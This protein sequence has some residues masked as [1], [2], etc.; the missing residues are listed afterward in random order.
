MAKQK[1][2][3]KSR[4]RIAPYD[5][6]VGG[7][8]S[9]KG[10]TE[11][12][13][14]EAVPLSD[15][16]SLLKQNKSDGFACVSCSY[17]RPDEPGLFEICEN[18]AK[19]TAWEIT[20]K[21][22]GPDFFAEHTVAELESWSDL[23]LE[24]QGRL[25]E[26]MRWDADSDKY[27]PCS[28][29]EAFEGIA[30]ELRALEPEETVFYTSGR[31]SLEASY[32]YQ[33]LAR[34]YGNNN[35][36]DSSNMC[37]ES[38]S[39]ALPQTIGQAVG[40]V[41]I[42][43]FKHTECVMFFGQNVG[44]NSPRMLHQLEAVRKRDV[45]ILSFNPLFERGLERF[46]NP[47]SP[48]KMLTGAETQ[49]STQYH[50]LKP[51]GDL[52]TLVGMTKTLF[53]MD[54]E[55][56][57]EGRERI[58]DTDFIEKHTHG[59]DEFTAAMDQFLWRDI[60][61]AS[62]LTRADIEA[63]AKVYGQA[64]AVIA[65]YGMGLTQHRS[66]VLAIQM[67]SNLLLLCG[68]IGK[69]GAGIF[70]VRG[71]S[72]VQGQRTV[73][74]TE[75]PKLAPL[76]KFAEQFGFEPPR[77][78]GRD[79]VEACQGVRDGSVKAFVSL[80]GNFIRAIPETEI[81]ERAWRDMKLTVQIITKLNRGAIVHGKTAYLLPCLGRI[82]LDRQKSGIQFVTVEDTTGRYHASYGYSEPASEHLLSEPAIVA[83]MAKALLPENPKVDWDGWVADYAKV[84]DAIATSY[85][86]IFHDFNTRIK[87]NPKGFDRPLPAREREW[88]TPTGKANFISPRSL[89]EDP[90]LPA[91]RLGV[92]TL[93]TLRSNDQFNTTVYGLDDRLRGIDGTRMVLLMNEADMEEWE[94]NEGDEIDLHGAAADNVPR[95]VRGLRVVKYNIPQGACGGYYPECN[96]LLPLW[97]HAKGS[98]VPAAKSIPVRIVKREGESD[99][100]PLIA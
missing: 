5:G 79:T 83:G 58:L 35:L 8:G 25:T 20:D 6:P 41:K 94:L 80:G 40:T 64:D 84:R 29:D 50:Q 42:E 62:G 67:L 69:P 34:L 77:E 55:A 81:M 9:L 92:L 46:T 76:D 56:K 48:I 52:A 93:I 68:N 75:K 65:C 38:T 15:W 3:E 60:E 53:A 26:P 23:E 100:L 85:P 21:R 11:I 98:N 12:M 13:W 36:P 82:E 59:F 95:V 66:G 7:W 43:D 4:V 39:V 99:S 74:I 86:E 61:S 57:A 70:P 32:M 17:G 88:E 44:V 96:P 71:H 97:H 28:W 30:S 19:A 54:Q 27:V 18:G 16:P 78:K 49:I 73:G 47:A 87:E 24:E 63:A 37:H 31:A 45:P 33:L 22:C 89:S 90:D 51:G 2:R 14:R 1:P 72:N 91:T 10:V